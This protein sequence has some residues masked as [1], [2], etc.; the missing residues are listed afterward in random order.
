MQK[1]YED[2]SK[3]LLEPTSLNDARLHTVE[4]RVKEAEEKQLKDSGFFVNVFKKLLFSI[5]QNEIPDKEFDQKQGILES[6]NS[7][8]DNTFFPFIQ[9]FQNI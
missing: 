8:G 1:K 6:M 9:E 7:P 5:E 2:W 4:C 3:A